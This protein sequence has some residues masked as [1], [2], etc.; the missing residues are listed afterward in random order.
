VLAAKSYVNTQAEKMIAP[1]S[2][3]VLEA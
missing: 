1:C 3:Q 2:I